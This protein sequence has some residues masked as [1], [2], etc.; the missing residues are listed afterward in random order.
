MLC[1][2]LRCQKSFR[3]KHISYKIHRWGYGACE[4]VVP[5]RTKVTNGK[6]TYPTR[7]GPTH[8]LQGYLAHKK[9]PPPRTLQ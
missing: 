9:H 1:G 7:P 4:A 3:L 8:R 2:K 6:V 5:R